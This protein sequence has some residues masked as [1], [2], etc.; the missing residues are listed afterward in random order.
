MVLFSLDHKKLC[1]N[2]QGKGIPPIASKTCLR[3]LTKE[4]RRISHMHP[5]APN[6]ISH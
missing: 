5:G 2:T 6:I 4:T 3:I 1:V